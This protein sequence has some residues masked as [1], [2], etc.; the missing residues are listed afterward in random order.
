MTCI[1][2][3]MSLK[4]DQVRP[5]TT[6]LAALNKASEKIDVSIFSSFVQS[7]SGEHHCPLG[8]LLIYVKI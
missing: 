6:D 4:F 3:S 5:R 1:R 8:Y 7:L 2:A